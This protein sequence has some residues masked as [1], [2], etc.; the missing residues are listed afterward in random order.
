MNDKTV[1][2][3]RIYDFW[4]EATIR[5]VINSYDDVSET[6]DTNGNYNPEIEKYIQRS[7]KL[8]NYKN[9]ER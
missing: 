7:V 2:R 8:R 9:N 6:T 3:A 1:I 5:V 4:V